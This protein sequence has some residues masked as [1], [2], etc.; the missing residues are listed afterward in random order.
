MDAV[1]HP[2]ASSVDAAQRVKLGTAMQGTAM[3]APGRTF[4]GGGVKQKLIPVGWLFSNKRGL[5]WM[6]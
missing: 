4:R 2:G 3:E 5:G 1:L 6:G